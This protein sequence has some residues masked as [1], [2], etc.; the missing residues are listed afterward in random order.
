VAWVLAQNGKM[1]DADAATLF[2]DHSGKDWRDVLPHVDVPALV[3]AAEASVLPAAGVQW[4]ASQMPQAE[5]VTF[6]ADE[7][8]SHMLFWQNPDKF[9][10]VVEEFVNQHRS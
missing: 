5:A 4:L 8:G 2:L 3:V 6:G 9:N 1:S 7:G 10:R